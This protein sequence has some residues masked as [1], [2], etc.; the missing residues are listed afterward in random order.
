MVF[1]SPLYIFG[2]TDV[3]AIPHITSYGVHKKYHAVSLRGGAGNIM[4]R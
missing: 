1:E 4:H 3:D 2:M